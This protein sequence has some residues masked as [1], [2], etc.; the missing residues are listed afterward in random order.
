MDQISLP[1]LLLVVALIAMGIY[2]RRRFG[3]LYERFSEVVERATGRSMRSIVQGLA[4]LTL[5]LWAVVYLTFGGD[6][7]EGLEAIFQEFLP[8]SKDQARE[9]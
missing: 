9:P 6:Q 5:I 3:N 2:V 4:I 7:K 1:L 8:D